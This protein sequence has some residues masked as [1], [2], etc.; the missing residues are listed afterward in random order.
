M[1]KGHTTHIKHQQ[2]AASSIIDSIGDDIMLLFSN[3]SNAFE[4]FIEARVLHSQLQK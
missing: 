2:R 3:V 4:P 1:C